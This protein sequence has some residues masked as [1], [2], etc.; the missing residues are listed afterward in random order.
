MNNEEEAQKPSEM[1]PE[2]LPDVRAFQDEF[3]REFLKSTEESREGYYPFLSGTGKYE[4]DFPAEG[5]IGEEGYTEKD[6]GIENYMAGV[7]LEGGGMLITAVY[8][9]IMNK[10]TEEQNLN[11]IEKSIGEDLDF[12]KKSLEDRTIYFAEYFLE[13]EDDYFVAYI[14]NQ[15]DVG[16]V[17][18]DFSIDSSVA[19]DQNNLKEDIK[20]IVKSVKFIESEEKVNDDNA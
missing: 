4:M 15:N 1:N 7:E 2:D 8:N 6:N 9:T 10:E 20:K 11:R 19:N 16:G 17:E 12:E 3:T 13:D 18:L 14:Q 5:I